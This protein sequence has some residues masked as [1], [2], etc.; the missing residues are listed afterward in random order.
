MRR[1]Q[2]LL[3][4]AWAQL[5]RTW[6]G[7][8][9][10]AVDGARGLHLLVGEALLHAGH[11]MLSQCLLHALVVGLDGHILLAQAGERLD[12]CSLG[13]PV[14][15]CA[16]AH[17]L[18]CRG[19]NLPCATRTGPLFS[20]SNRVWAGSWPTNAAVEPLRGDAVLACLATRPL[21]TARAPA[22]HTTPGELG[23]KA[24]Q[25]Q[26]SPAQRARSQQRS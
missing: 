14:R 1:P 24:P 20:A 11:A 18:G 17:A 10:P 7:E 3:Q 22:P 16:T 9:V 5:M 12:L 6:R 8:F 21:W 13:A 4:F 19:D 15:S 2:Q 25:K 26:T 23:G